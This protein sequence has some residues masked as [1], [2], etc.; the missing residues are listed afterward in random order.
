MT[1][2][3]TELHALLQFDRPLQVVDIGANPIDG[4]PPYKVLLDAGLCKVTGFEPQAEALDR[5]NAA[6]SL[7]ETYLPY[8]VGDGTAKTLNIC[9]YSGWTSTLTPS[10]ASLNVFS[11]F[12]ENAKVIEQTSI[13]TQRLD[14]IAEVAEIDFLKIDIQGGELDVFNNAKR[15]LAH[16]SVIQ[17]EVSFINLY[18]GQPSFGDVDVAL[19]AQGF[20]AHTFAAI[21]KGIISPFMLNGD[22]WRPLNQLLEGDVVYVR[23][24]RDPAALSDHQLKV[25]S[26]VAHACYGSFDLSYRCLLLLRERGALGPDADGQYVELVNAT[27]RRRAE[28][29]G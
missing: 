13:E 25:M 26:L 14:D 5:L 10:A 15:K 24:F 28:K 1:A 29:A 17:T 7:H 12:T 21:K 23:D 16:A 4:D 2:D 18:E 9:R 3:I 27:L 22:P 8:A 6:K 11:A 20:V 19:R